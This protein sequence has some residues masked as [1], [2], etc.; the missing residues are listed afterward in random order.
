MNDPDSLRAEAEARLR[1][2]QAS[3]QNQIHSAEDA[4]HELQVYQIELEMQ[5]DNLRR[6]MIDLEKSRDRYAD[7]YDFAPV[8][9]ITLDQDGMIDEINLTG[10]A[11]LRV[12][13]CNLL[14][15]RFANFVAA[16]SRDNWHTHFL[17]IL[18]RDDTQTCELVLQRADGACFYAQLSCLSRRENANQSSLRI[19]LTD[20]TQN[21]MMEDDLRESETRSRSLMQSS[22]DGIHVLDAQG[23]VVE[24]NDAFC[25]MLGYTREEIYG[26]NLI[27]WAMGLRKEELQSRLEERIGKNAMLETL[28]RRKDGSLIHVEISI[29]GFNLAG[30]VFI[31]CASRDITARKQNETV[32]QRYKQVIETALDGFWLTDMQ[33][34]LLEANEA[35]AQMS[36]YSVAELKAMRISQLEAKE[37]PEEVAAH[38]AE[39]STKGYVRFESRHRRKDG[40]VIDVEVAAKTLPEADQLVVFTRDITRRKQAEEAMAR[41]EANMRAILD[42][43]PYLTWLKD[44]DGRYLTVNKVFLEFL[45]LEDTRQTIGKSDFDLHPRELAEK[46]LADDVEVM[47]T[48]RRKHVVESAFDGRQKRWV[49]TFK[50]PIVDSRGTVLGTV[51]VAKDITER[52]RAEEALRIAAATFETHDAILITDVNANIVRVN[53]AFTDITGYTPEDVLGKNPR[54]MSSGRQDKAFYMEMWQQLRHTGSWA[55][56]IWDKRKNG[57]IYPKWLTISAVCNEQ[58]EVTH[59]VAIFSDITARKHAEEE[60]R[61]LAFYDALTKLPNRRLFMDRFRAALTISARNQNYGGVL[62]IDMD[63]FKVLNDTLGHDYGD[64]LLVEVAARIK[65]CV[66]EMDTVARLGGDEFVVLIEGVGQAQHEVSRHVGFIAEKIRETLAYPYNLK[67]HEHHSSPSIGISL[68]MGH[69]NKV[70]DL[71]QQADMAMYQA[72]NAGRNTVRFFDPVMQHNV[73]TRAALEDDLHHAISLGQL[74]LHYQVQVDDEHRPLGA[75]AL[76][77]W[78]HSERGLV[79]PDDFIPIAEES[80]LILDIGNWVLDQACHQLAIWSADELTRD[81]T[82][83]VNVSAKQFVQPNFVEQISLLLQLHQIQPSLLK[84]ELTESMVVHDLKN[85]I[86]TMHALKKLGVMLSMDDFGTGY[87]SLSYLRDLPLDQIKID[88]SFIQSITRDGNDAQLVQTIIDL[89]ANFRMKVIAEGVETQAQ[90]TFLKYHECTN[91]QGFLFGKAMAINEFEALLQHMQGRHGGSAV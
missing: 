85:T 19:V 49:E 37:L 38:I 76:L 59:Y 75:E 28:H 60:I 26:L 78:I 81:L 89:A 50:T 1:H 41:S 71:L 16:E 48:G 42:N 33:G 69:E 3:K 65:S 40:A 63:R 20:H 36:G 22:M 30:Q 12:D 34:N 6:L 15:H 58:Q 8:G 32:L 21:K 64:M 73:A 47:S 25:K 90:L 55:G 70:D 77:R 67:S 11:M 54:I 7:F 84:L 62:F 23:N 74:Q 31:F 4:L 82:L 9:Y 68:F 43:S 72:K 5:N 45:Q 83:A 24:A 86:I 14:H 10:A 51:G 44:K 57:Q 52:M 61:N 39:L 53:R 79:M 88:Q 2:T 46:Y 13:R 35:Y 17:N 66:R 91:Y 27:D 29:S 80:T 56:E 18:K 87:S